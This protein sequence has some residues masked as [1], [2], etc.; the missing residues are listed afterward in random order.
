[1]T[2]TDEQL[3]R[4]FASGRS[5]AAFRTLAERHLGLVFHTALRRTGRRPMAEEISQNVL[6]AMAKK[7]GALAEN[8]AA[9][10]GWLHRATLF[11]CT[12][13]MRKEASQ[14][15]RKQLQHPDDLPFTAAKEEPAAHW[16]RALPHLDRAL[17]A[18]PDSDRQVLLLHFYERQPFPRIAAQLGRSAAAVQKQSVRALEKLAKA[19]RAKGVAANSV[20]LA[21]GLATESAKAS[22]LSLL[23]GISKTALA[24]SGGL[25]TG[26]RMAM[27][28]SSH[29]KAAIFCG[30]LMLAL[31]L[32]AQ[33][34]E[35]ATTRRELAELRAGA[36]STTSTAALGRRP[37]RDRAH[38]SSVSGS[39]DLV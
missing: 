39:L 20:V 29:P 2:A 4:T 11:E 38:D 24:G 32:A 10:P 30:L 15:R 33:Y 26:A 17:D 6:C 14:Q 36:S 37:A 5:E 12:I 16:Q 7:A 3:L 28:F 19:L 34:G 18:L 25:S 1:M 21:T 13:A 31:P 27:I 22:P 23:P 35:I 9:L 8:A